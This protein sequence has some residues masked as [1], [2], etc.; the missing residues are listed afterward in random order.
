MG[1]IFLNNCRLVHDFYQLMQKAITTF[2]LLLSSLV[3]FSQ[4]GG[5]QTFFSLT[6]PTNSRIGALGGQDLAT[7]NNEC[8]YF[9]QN[10]ATLDKRNSNSIFFNYTPISGHVQNS[11]FGISH[12]VKKIGNLGV[13][14]Q[15]LDYG[16]FENTSEQGVDLGETFYAKDFAASIGYSNSLTEKMNY[17]I[18]L[19]YIYSKIETYKSAGIAADAGL[20]FQDT[21]TGIT[22]GLDLK[23]I[24]TVLSDFT[25]TATSN[26]PFDLQFGISKKLSHTPFTLFLNLHD[27]YKFDIRYPRTETE[28]QLIV[29]STNLRVKK[30][31]V[32]KIFLHA[33]FGIQI[34]FGKNL[35]LNV[36]YNHQRRDELGYSVR[37]GMS[38][39]SFGVQISIKKINLGYS[40]AVYNISGGQ[41]NLSFSLNINQLVG[42]RKM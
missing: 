13:G 5:Q 11:V 24:G 20:V 39:F 35:K 26:L 32:D 27:L 36:G 19:K 31:T 4:N 30:Y 37:K 21:A 6:F 2:F 16:I 15:F 28:T 7:W 41:N 10:P 3:S 14:I 42:V 8:A 25:E 40:Y 29:D 38:G 23:N 18:S 1:K 12:T 17:G 33:N 22:A 9:F 34:D